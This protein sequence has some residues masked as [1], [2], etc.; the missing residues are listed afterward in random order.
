M[1]KIEFENDLPVG[2]HQ[3]E[4][5]INCPTKTAE[6]FDF[7]LLDDLKDTVRERLAGGEAFAAIIQSLAA[8]EAELLMADRLAVFVALIRSSKKPILFLD[9]LWMLSGAALREGA[10]I[11][12]LAKKHGCSKQ[13]F[14]QAM[15]R[16]ADRFPF[17]KT[18]TERSETAKEHMRE[19]Y[20][21]K[22]V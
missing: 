6:D 20:F 14:Q 22:T 10:T 18:R 9:C 15:E 19:A 16:V 5:R 13:A 8:E 17:P 2:T 12:S 11:Q 21:P 3:S 7:D 4:A 1:S